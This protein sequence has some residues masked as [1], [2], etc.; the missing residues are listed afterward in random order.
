MN[1]KYLL[2]ALALAFSLPS[3]AQSKKSVTVEQ[4]IYVDQQGVIR[5][6]KNHQEAAFFGV[7]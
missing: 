3:V 2:F 4:G 1:K 6:K 5:W 7:N